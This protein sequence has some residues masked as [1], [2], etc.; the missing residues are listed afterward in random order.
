MVGRDRRVLLDGEL[1][2]DLGGVCE[3]P[4]E[5]PKLFLGIP[6][7][8]IGDLDVSTFDLKSH[9]VSFFSPVETSG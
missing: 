8:L 2:L 9:G 7:D 5:P 3:L 6:P 4:L 1:E